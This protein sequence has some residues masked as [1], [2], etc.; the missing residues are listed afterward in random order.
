METKKCLNISQINLQR[1]KSVSSNLCLLTQQ[2]KLDLILIQEPYTSY[3]MA[4]MLPSGLPVYQKSTNGIVKRDI[5]INNSDVVCTLIP[6]HSN[7]KFVCINLQYHGNDI[8]FCSAYFEPN[9]NFDCDLKLISDLLS[10]IKPLNFV[11]CVDAN[12][13][14]SV[15]FNITNDDRGQKLLDLCAQF[16]LII[17]N[18]SNEPTFETETRKGW[19]DLS[20]VSH[21]ISSKVRNWRVMDEET[22]SDHRM[23]SFNI[24]FEE[25]S[26]NATHT[27][28]SIYNT[29]RANW[30][31]FEKTIDKLLTDIDPN[32]CTNSQ[33]LDYTV[34]FI[35]KAIQTACAKHIPLKKFGLRQVPWWSKE[36]FVMRKRVNA[37]RR[38]FSRARE[39]L[40]RGLREQEYK[41]Y[42]QTY[43]DLLKASK[44]N[45]W[46]SF[47]SAQEKEDVWST[48]HRI[49][50]SFMH[51]QI[52]PTYLRKLDGTQTTSNAETALVMLK[53]FFPDNNLAHNY[54]QSDRELS[55]FNTENT[56][57]DTHKFTENEVMSIIKHLNPKKAPGEDNINAEVIKRF[58]HMKPNFLSKLYNRCFELQYFPKLWK[59]AVVKVIPKTGYEDSSN[60][61][62]YRPIC[63]LS[64]LGKVLEK[65]IINR[66]NWWIL[67]QNKISANQFGFLPQR[68]T[69]QAIHNVVDFAKESLAMKGIC[70]LISLDITGAFDHA[71]WD[72]IIYQMKLKGFPNNLIKLTK[73]YYTDRKV[74]LCYQEVSFVKQTTMGCPQGSVSGPCH[75]ILVYDDLAQ[76]TLPYGCKINTYAD[77]AL[78]M[79]S[80]NSG[81]EIEV[82]TN[83]CLRIVIENGTKHGLT[84]NPNK[85]YAMVLTNKLKY[86]TPRLFMGG[87]ELQLVDK[88]RYLGVILDKK[89]NFT[90]HIE[91]VCSKVERLTMH[92]SRAIK[93]SWG[94][95]YDVVKIIYRSVIEPIIL[96]C[97]SV[98]ADAAQSRWGSR[99]LERTQRNISIRMCKSYR[100][101]SANAVILLS[102]F[103]PLH[104][105]ALEISDLYCIKQTGVTD[106]IG[107]CGNNYQ[108]P[109]NV[110]YSVHPAQRHQIN[111]IFHDMFICQNRHKY[112]IFTDGSKENE[113]VGAGYVILNNVLIKSGMAKLA[114]YCSVFQAE[115]V[116]IRTAL[117]WFD[118]TRHCNITIELSSDSRAALLAI[119]DSNS[120][121]MI[122]NDIH[123]VLD[124]LNSKGIIVRFSWVKGHSGIYGNELADEM[125]KKAST[126][127]LRIS[128]DKM[129]LSFTK[130][131]LREK[132]IN[133]WNNNYIISNTGNITKLYFPTVYHRLHLRELTPDFITTQF[134]T[135]HGKFNAYLYRFKVKTSPECECGNPEQTIEHLI[136]DCPRYLEFR[137]QL[138]YDLNSIN[139]SQSTN[140]SHYT[141]NSETFNI[142]KL[143]IYKIYK[144]L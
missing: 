3:G 128:Y 94:L 101:V 106:A 63:L 61:K 93:P 39:P 87:S 77:D 49:C 96:Y 74:R 113:N 84:F 33:D 16:N 88:F 105:R 81:E 58:N 8:I 125:A 24:D 76:E 22:M 73:S 114:S 83:E 2:F 80:G 140:F 129:P 53:T 127:H 97:S 95:R 26:V 134:L 120:L 92:L 19:I 40:L 7:Q 56:N 28:T 116:G 141:L 12:A 117:Q 54:Q 103:L 57:I 29:N 79:V 102:G 59:S 48:V 99:R 14:S 11:L 115:L 69:E 144:S 4:S 5:I 42:K 136:N 109:L 32:S 51:R 37:L 13:K 122:V 89:L 46:K 31:G 10:D 64:I 25:C 30:K 41:T 18:N 104:L 1:S 85:T 112:H 44:L 139:Q 131:M 43:K 130:K 78:I 27:M 143:Y 6:Q 90:A 38:R 65:L 34:N 118:T 138:Y 20:I 142:F 23:I 52:H 108:K 100:T 36:L 21:G 35:T 132:Y 17:L 62:A 107:F 124:S 82:K 133:I 47:C 86:T 70:A 15:W 50:K 60:L 72:D 45:S 98:W 68:T 123:T 121:N 75:W 71:R 119:N 111:L 91:S 66:I 135:G 55:S 110:K 9:S 137:M 126:S 67:S